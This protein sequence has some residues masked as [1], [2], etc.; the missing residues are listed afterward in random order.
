M[1]KIHD[2]SS[3]KKVI[4]NP[5]NKPTNA[6]DAPDLLIISNCVADKSNFTSAK[7]VTF[8]DTQKLDKNL[9]TIFW[10]IN[11]SEINSNNFII[12][13]FD[14]TSLVNIYDDERKYDVIVRN[15]QLVVTNTSIFMF[16]FLDIGSYNN[17][18]SSPINS[19][20]I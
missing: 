20:D 11:I 16:P 8:I 6:Q 5:T 13:N 9:N 4:I 12:K 18:Q 2:N 7:V 17:I 1:K 10:Y 19:Y 14:T 15:N 3:F